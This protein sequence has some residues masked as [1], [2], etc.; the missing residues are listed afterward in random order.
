MAFLKEIDDEGDTDVCD[1]EDVAYERRVCVPF[2]ME[3]PSIFGVSY[4]ELPIR[5]ILTWAAEEYKDSRELLMNIREEFYFGDHPDDYDYLVDSGPVHL[6]SRE[7]LAIRRLALE[8]DRGAREMRRLGFQREDELGEHQCEEDRGAREAARH[9]FRKE[10]EEI[11]KGKRDC[12]AED[13]MIDR[14]WERFIVERDSWPPERRSEMERAERARL[15]ALDEQL[16]SRY[17]KLSDLE[18]ALMEKITRRGEAE[19]K[20]ASSASS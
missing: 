3:C 2:P 19:A 1:Q 15:A 16:Q 18:F 11:R 10:D 8:K 4:I 9:S 12:W 5:K 20:F 7:E 6:L 14:E 17:G 13:E